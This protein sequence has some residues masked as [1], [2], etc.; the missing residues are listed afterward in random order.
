VTE[1]VPTNLDFTRLC[2]CP[3]VAG[4]DTVLQQEELSEEVVLNADD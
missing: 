3:C 2:R 1:R 4:L